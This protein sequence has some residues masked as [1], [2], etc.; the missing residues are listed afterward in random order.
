MSPLIGYIKQKHFYY[1]ID[2]ANSELGLI[3]MEIW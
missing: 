1:V 3:I 2:Y